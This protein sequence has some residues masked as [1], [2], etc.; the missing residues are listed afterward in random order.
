ML[1]GSCLCQGVTH[2]LGGLLRPSVACHCTQCRKTSG[3][4]MSAT[5][6]GLDLLTITRDET[7]VWCQSSEKAQRGFCDRCGPSVFWRHEEDDSAVRVM[8]G[9]PDGPTGLKTEKHIYVADKGDYYDIAD[10]L[11]QREN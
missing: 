10:G 6:F 2:S 1:T 9:T 5:Q 11:P 7:L 4:Y 8:S 3:H